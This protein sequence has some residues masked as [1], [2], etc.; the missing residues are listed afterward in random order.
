MERKGADHHWLYST[1]EVM[2]HSIHLSDE[3]FRAYERRAR[4][5]GLTVAEYLD[6]SAPSDDQFSLTPEMRAGIERGLA[7]ADAGK[8]VG[9]DQVRE[10]LTQYRAGWRASSN[11]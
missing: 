6:R 7:Q 11:R 2:H 8:L 1:G 10:S 9:L 3:A 4:R 5:V